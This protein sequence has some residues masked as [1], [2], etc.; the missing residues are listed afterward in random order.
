MEN[1]GKTFAIIVILE[2][3]QNFVY[4][5][6]VRCSEILAHDQS[7]KDQMGRGEDRTDRLRKFKSRRGKWRDEYFFFRLLPDL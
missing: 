1:S 3:Q 7:I 2:S 5:N 6:L 4:L